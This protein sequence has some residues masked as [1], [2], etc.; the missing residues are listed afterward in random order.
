FPRRA[1]R[2]PVARFTQRLRDR[3]AARSTRHMPARPHRIAG[4]QQVK[5]VKHAFMANEKSADY[6]C[7]TSSARL[8]IFATSLPQPC[9]GFR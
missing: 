3:R 4:L 7:A 6:G 5:M 1:M 8:A 2:A 9:Q